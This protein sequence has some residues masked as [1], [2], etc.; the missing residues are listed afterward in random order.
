MN[1]RCTSCYIYSH[2]NNNYMQHNKFSNEM[3][4]SEPCNIEDLKE[5]I[6]VEQVEILIRSNIVI[7]V[8]HGLIL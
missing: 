1:K 3:F 2:M 5:I 7:M 8:E 6:I 4:N